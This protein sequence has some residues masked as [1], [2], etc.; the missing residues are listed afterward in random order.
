MRKVKQFLL[1]QLILLPMFFIPHGTRI[2]AESEEVTPELKQEFERL[3][4][5]LDLSQW[6]EYFDNMCESFNGIFEFYDVEQMVNSIAEN[7]DVLKIKDINSLK[8]WLISN[9]RPIIRPMSEIM[10]MGVFGGLCA[11]LLGNNSGVGKILQLLTVSIVIVCV[12]MIYA[13]IVTETKNCLI[14]ISDFCS[15]SA[16]IILALMNM[17]GYSG[18]AGIMSPM[19]IIVLN[20]ALSIILKFVIPLVL[21]GGMFTTI[22]NIND[23]LH[24]TKIVRFTGSVS[25]W[26]LGLLTTIYL[27]VSTLGGFVR[28]I[29]DTVSI[30][31]ARYAIEKM[32]PAVGGMVSGAVDAVVGGAILLKNAVGITAVLILIGI[33]LKP[34]L[35]YIGIMMALRIT[36]AIVGPFAGERISDT[37]DGIANNVSY[38]FASVCAGVSMFAVNSFIMISLGNSLLT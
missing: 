29:T 9:L 26:T 33:A 35:K 6:Q 34:L 12:I 3:L 1:V 21:V 30:K 37:L 22:N 10:V 20:G 18:T 19:M 16:P 8:T 2:L 32:I 27:A 13:D 5:E 15:I 17:M 24:L 14:Q 28:S 4:G 23:K 36:S 7:D 38:L 25:K 31:T 11:M